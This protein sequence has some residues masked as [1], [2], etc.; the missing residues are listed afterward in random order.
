VILAPR[1][2][3]WTEALDCKTHV[4]IVCPGCGGSGA[5]GNVAVHHAVELAKQFSV[6][7]ISDG[8]PA[9]DLPGVT[10]VGIRP[11]RFGMLRRFA[12]VPNEIAFALRAR[13]AITALHARLPVDFLLCHGHPMATLAAR[14]VKR[15]CGVPYGLV[16]HGDIFDRPKGTYDPRLTWFYKQV[17]AT[18]YRNADLVVALSPHMAELARR[19]G[20]RPDR[21]VVIPN[22]I[23]PAEIGLDASETVAPRTSG[24]RLELLYVGRLSVE[25][26]VDV[27]LGAAE[28]L[29]DRGV[30][31]GLR[32]VGVGP[33]RSRLCARIERAQLGPMV[34]MLENV[35]RRALGP[36]YRSVDLVCVPSRSDTLPTVVLEAM[37]ASAVVVGTD[38]GG[39][40][41]MVKH[42]VTGVVCA[43]DSAW[44]FAEALVDL[45][46]HPDA[47]QRMRRAAGL[48][49]TADFSW[50]R[51]GQA[52]QQAIRTHL[53]TSSASET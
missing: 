10:T 34:R 24:D 36:L 33:E 46:S 2:Q 15:K 1:R 4:V 32:I 50:A 8:F 25:K 45:A 9:G 20:A 39:I 53:P 30:N 43:P 23:D 47:I 3:D 29:R 44:A 28:I 11:A 41:Y 37:A 16:T 51:V 6:T 31:F 38:V 17:T 21:I 14:P 48:K 13:A 52:L 27:L 18:A 49:A 22:G 26:G 19:G 40:P 12:H 42:G 5:V 7:L 35:H